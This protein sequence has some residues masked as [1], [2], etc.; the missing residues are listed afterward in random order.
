MILG[1][2][3]SLSSTPTEVLITK[4]CEQKKWVS[5][6]RSEHHLRAQPNELLPLVCNVRGLACLRRSGTVSANKHDIRV[7][8]PIRI[9]NG[10]VSFGLRQSCLILS[11]V[12]YRLSVVGAS[13]AR[14]I[15][16]YIHR[17][18]LHKYVGGCSDRF[19][20]ASIS[21]GLHLLHL[22]IPLAV[23]ITKQLDD[24]RKLLQGM[25]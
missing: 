9:V 2:N 19:G 22:P 23:Y 17:I 25:P 11:A 18:V 4:T 3:Y 13:S 10:A 16:L 14:M 20:S 6:S 5:A 21:T 24:V 15:L 7:Y 12:G 8:V 1:P